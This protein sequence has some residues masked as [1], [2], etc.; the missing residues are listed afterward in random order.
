MKKAFFVT[1]LGRGNYQTVSYELAGRM[2]Q[3]RFAPVATAHFCGLAGA[4]AILLAT[5][6]VQ[7]STA[8]TDLADELIAEGLEVEVVPIGERGDQD[9]LMRLLIALSERIPDGSHLTVDVTFALRHLPFLYHA[10]ITFLCGLREVTLDGIFY[11]AFELKQAN[12]SIPLVSISHAFNLVHWFQ[13][14]RTFRES[15]DANEIARALTRDVAKL[16]N[17]RAP[18]HAL[19]KFKDVANRLAEALAFGL[20]IEAGT[21][22]GELSRAAEL[23]QIP[24]SSASASYLGAELLRRAVV[25]WEL[26]PVSGKTSVALDRTELERQCRFAEWLLERGQLSGALEMLREFIVNA[27]LVVLAQTD[28]WLDRRARFNAE[29]YLNALSERA[30]SNL[31]L[32][33][34][35]KRLASIWDQVR[36]R[37]NRVAHAG[38]DASDARISKSRVGALFSECRQLLDLRLVPSSTRSQGRLLVTALGL[39]PGVLFSALKRT[40]PDRLLVVTSHEAGLSLDKILKISGFAGIEQR[41]RKVQDPH[42]GFAEDHILIDAEIDRYLVASEQVIVNMTGGTT[43]L[44]W[45]VQRVAERATRLGVPLRRIAVIDRRPPQMQHEEPY[46]L[47]DLT[48]LQP[49][50]QI[51]AEN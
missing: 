38:M 37:R 40:E 44:Q 45:L 51:A 25:G 6:Q 23:L 19:S 42:A 18:D 3:T 39:S 22:A 20:P 14:L 43:A 17:S 41:V 9:E 36:E 8:C 34:D 12:G 26:S 47:G 49:I 13:A 35:E 48:E 5:P 30:K 50:E 10:A 21:E 32:A 1:S 2:K 11:G 7:E 16:F 31:E 29:G 15:G 27:T 24:S 4:S 46:V 28:Q 33:P